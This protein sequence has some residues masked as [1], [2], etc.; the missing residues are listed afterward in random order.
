MISFI[1]IG[2]N[3]GWKLTKCLQSIFDTIEYNALKEYEVIYVDSKSTDDSIERV[4]AFE[5]VRVFKL[6]G[7]INAAIARNLGAKESSRDVFFFV[8]GDMEIQPEF[9]PLV[10]SEKE[11]LI[12]DF[13]SSNWMDYYYNQ[14][15]EFISKSPYLKMN[16]DI[17]ET[18]TGGLFLIKREI[19]N[20]VGGMRS[21]FKKSQDID[22]GL[23]L[24]K[25][26]VFLLRKKE[27]AAIHHT[28]AYMDKNRMWRDFWSGNE[29]YG[30]SLLYRKNILNLFTYKRILRNDY[31][32][33]VFIISMLL[34]PFSF[35]PVYFYL[36]IILLKALK[37][38]LKTPFNYFIYFILRDIKV[39]YGLF[40]FFPLTPQNI[41]YNII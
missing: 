8:D 30:R 17:K 16:Q 14:K 3:E 9:L 18:T 6:T 12:N 2:R 31:S 21:I 38:S 19:W 37:T 28:I 40:F 13:V 15:G 7:D 1:I 36:I 5:N 29:L 20:S 32:L 23:R 27:V 34:L 33:L 24:A 41:K 39:L 26:G 22:L 35:I 25:K 4:K 11:G 10:Y